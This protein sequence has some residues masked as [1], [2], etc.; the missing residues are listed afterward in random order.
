MPNTTCTIDNCGKEAKAPRGWCWKHYNH[1]RRQGDPLAQFTA[2][3]CS[4]TGCPSMSRVKGMCDMHYRRVVATGDPHKGRITYPATCTA[5][6]CSLPSTQ[7]GMCG[8]H[9]YVSWT[10]EGNG[11]ALKAAASARRRARET[12][13]TTAEPRLSWL[14]LW[15]E[16]VQSCY[17]CDEPCNRQDFRVITN[18]AGRQQMIPGPT[19]PTLDHITALANGGAHTRE[20][21]GL[22]CSQ[23]NRRKHAKV[24]YGQDATKQFATR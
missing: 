5:S 4:I 6:D 24:N 7:R 12:A 10:T 11:R 14:L 21:A 17:L 16:G 22:A 8:P 13:K 19:Y 2:Q 23:C 1:W 18:R 9:Y 3:H 20:N 15:D